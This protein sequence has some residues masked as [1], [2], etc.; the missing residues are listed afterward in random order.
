MAIYRAT[1]NGNQYGQTVDVITSW[2]NVFAGSTSDANKLADAVGE[3]WK[4]NVLHD[5]N[6]SY[7]MTGVTVA[8][9]DEPSFGGFKSY[10]EVGAVNLDPAS[11]FLVARVK[12]DTGLRGR[13]YQGRF[14]IPA[15]SVTMVDTSNPNF[16]ESGAQGGLQ[17][18]VDGFVSDVEAH[19]G[20]FSMMVVSLIKDGSPRT[21]PLDTPVTSA[22]VE[23][24]LG[25]RNSRKN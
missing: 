3:A 12:L 23:L 19:D 1:I 17:T 16:L 7:S 5:L 15:L 25:T 8:C 9:I 24:P 22:T 18:D 2:S 6:L 10:A 14:G 4:D 11:V 20:S 21:A 13:S